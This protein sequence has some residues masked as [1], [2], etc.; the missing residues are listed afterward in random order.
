MYPTKNIHTTFRPVY[1]HVKHA[2][3]Y[4][5]KPLDEHDTCK[6]AR[7]ET[8]T[9]ARD[10]DFRLIGKKKNRVGETMLGRHVEKP[11]RHGKQ[12]GDR[13][14]S[15]NA[16]RGGLGEIRETPAASERKSGNAAVYGDAR[17]GP[18]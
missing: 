17:A 16:M 9:E 13:S 3:I 10:T 7:V 15:E 11:E 4:V 1:A 8:G 12:P 18:A 2:I 14:S 6:T 5:M